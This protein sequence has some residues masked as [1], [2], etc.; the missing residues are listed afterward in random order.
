MDIRHLTFALATLAGAQAAT[1]GTA[2]AATGLTLMPSTIML[3]GMRIPTG[4]ESPI[5]P[6]LGSMVQI[7][8]VAPTKSQA[9][10]GGRVSR[11]DMITQ[12]QSTAS[13]TSLIASAALSSASLTP[14]AAATECTQMV[15]PSAKS[16]NFQAGAGQKP[17]SS[18]DFLASK[19]L[20]VQRTAFDAQWSRVSHGGVSRRLANSLTRVAPGGASRGTLASV[21]S[22]TNSHVRYVDDRVQYGRPDYWA[23]ARATLSRRAGDCEDIAIVKMQLLSAIGVAR[24]DMYLTIA[25]DLARNSDHAV[26]V[27][28]LDGKYWLLDNATDELLDA[29]SSYDYRPILTYSQS[30]KWLHGY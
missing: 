21:N 30:G 5:Q 25:R 28:K 9:I 17:F 20:P 27:V 19:R 1:T 12:Q 3:A 15:L 24:N 4:C 16:F 23:G 10:L 2:M 26:L 14:A 29:S 11:L 7:S 18:D 6:G 22:W 13:S 8:G